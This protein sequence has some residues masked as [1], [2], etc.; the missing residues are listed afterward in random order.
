[1]FTGNKEVVKNAGKLSLLSA[2]YLF[3][4][5]LEYFKHMAIS[6]T[7]TWVWILFTEFKVV[8]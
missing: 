8:L 3:D 6:T 7:Q 1:M 2:M 5:Y 4:H